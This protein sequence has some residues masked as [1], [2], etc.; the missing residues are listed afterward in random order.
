LSYISCGNAKVYVDLSKK[1]DYELVNYAVLK[2]CMEDKFINFKFNKF[3][4]L[5]YDLKLIDESEYNI[6]FY[7]TEDTDKIAMYKAGF[8]PLLVDKLDKD[9]QIQNI[10]VDLVG[11]FICTEEFKEYISESEGYFKYE[12][13]KYFLI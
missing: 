5:L 7:G 12:L 9:E 3:A 10:A 4:M 11:N 2:I 1:N 13:E 6:Y 8:S